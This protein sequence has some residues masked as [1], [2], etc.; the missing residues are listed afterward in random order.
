MR[1]GL[2]LK[3]WITTLGVTMTPRTILLCTAF[4]V[5][6]WPM[7]LNAVTVDAKSNI[8]VSGQDSTGIDTQGGLFPVVA[9]SFVPGAG[10]SV[11]FNVTPSP[12][13]AA[14]FPPGNAAGNGDGASLSFPVGPTTG[15]DISGNGTN[16]ISG[17]T[18]H[19]RE[20]FLV[21]VFL[22]SAI[23]TGAGPS[24]LT[25]VSSGGSL[26]MD[27]DTNFSAVAL[28]QGF[29]IGD[30]RTGFN[31][32]A[33]T[34]QTFQVPSTA[35]RLFLGFADAFNN[36]TGPWGAYGDNSGA[37]AVTVNVQ[38]PV[39]VPESNGTLMVFGLGLAAVLIFQRAV[40]RQVLT[41][42]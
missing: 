39:A 32:A 21:G 22:D 19:G 4:V 27:T 23:P 7:P 42:E 34:L 26:N 28:G 40:R 11:S 14:A 41:R 2:T 6:T 3:N 12:L 1:K 18:F 29:A 38:N 8:F 36:F 17:I 33:G 5:A 37:L 13:A 16:G 30:G 31:N 25:F 24:S 9:Q 35:T 15:T 20:M 10:Q